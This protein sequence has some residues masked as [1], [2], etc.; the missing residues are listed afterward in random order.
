VLKPDHFKAVNDRYGH[1]EG[2]RALEAVAREMRRIV[3]PPN[4]VSRLRGDE[5]AVLLPGIRSEAARGLAVSL[6]RELERFT[7]GPAGSGETALGFRAGLSCST[8][9]AGDAALLADRAARNVLQARA[10]KSELIHG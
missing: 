7:V 10:T 1:E 9:G 4:A 3:K 8:R 5:F 2:D 6:L